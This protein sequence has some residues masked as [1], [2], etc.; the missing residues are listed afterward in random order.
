[1]PARAAASRAMSVVSGMMA[2]NG[3]C[4]QLIEQIIRPN[5]DAP[6]SF[7]EERDFAQAHGADSACIPCWTAASRTR[8]APETVS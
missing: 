7:A 2:E 5:S 8:V 6:A 1:V 4:I 3:I